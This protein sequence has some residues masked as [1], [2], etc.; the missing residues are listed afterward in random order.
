[1]VHAT[2]LTLQWLLVNFT[3]LLGSSYQDVFSHGWSLNGTKIIWVTE[4][5]YMH[6]PKSQQVI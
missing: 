2:T 6:E 3:F 4:S 1:M 5:K